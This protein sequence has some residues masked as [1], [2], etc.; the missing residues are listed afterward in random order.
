M[1]IGEKMKKAKLVNSEKELENYAVYYKG[2]LALYL[3]P[4]LA[5]Q[6]DLDMDDLENFAVFILNG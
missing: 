6:Q 5:V 1:D 3:S 4:R 2:K